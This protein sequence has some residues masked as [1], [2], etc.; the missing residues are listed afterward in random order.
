[1]TIVVPF[2][3]IG[4]CASVVMEL[5]KNCTGRFSRKI[6]PGAV[7]LS[8][9]QKSNKQKMKESNITGKLVIYERKKK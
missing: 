1:M 6:A 3:S 2:Y 8:L 5:K 7:I 4:N 9:R